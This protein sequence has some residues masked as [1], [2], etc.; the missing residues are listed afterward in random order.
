MPTISPLAEIALRLVVDRELIG[1]EALPELA[2]EQTG[3]ARHEVHLGGEEAAAVAPV[4]LRP[5]HR[6]LGVL[7]QAIGRLAVGREQRDPD[8]GAGVELLA[9]EH[10]RL[11]EAV[12]QT[13]GQRAR[14]LGVA[15]VG[16]QDHELVAA[17]PAD[18][19]GLAQAGMQALGRRLEQQIAAG[20]A[21]GVVDALEAVE[22]EQ[23]HRGDAVGAPR[24]RERMVE[25]VAEQRPIGQPGQRVVPRLVAH[26]RL[27][28]LQLGDVERDR[29]HVGDPAGIVEQ[30][31]LG[32]QQDAL[33][34]GA[35]TGD[36]LLEAR[37]GLAGLEH[38][39]V[40]H[41]V[42]GRMLL[43][44][45]LLQG[46]PDR[47]CRVDPVELLV[48]AVDQ[49]Q[50]AAAVDRA[51]RRGHG[52]DQA[53]QAQLAGAER[54]L[55]LLAA[56]D[57]LAPQLIG[58]L[59]EQL[60]L[61]AQ[62]QEIARPGAE[63]DVVDR[64]QEEVGGAR[65]QRLVAVGAVLV[66]RH[67]HDRNVA[68]AWQ[69]AEGA[70]EVGAVHARHLVVGDHQIG[71]RDQDRIERRL[72]AR[73]CFDPDSLLDRGGQPGKYVPIGHPV[74]DDDDVGHHKQQLG[75]SVRPINPEDNQPAGHA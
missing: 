62:G 6:E 66:D 32:G 29:H 22:V 34:I 65:L 54:R 31:R 53:P 30:R 43:A 15:D 74:I 17:E 11:A 10:E 57:Q 73:E 23:Q 16:L 58:A 19:V 41:Q 26:L 4:G 3:A 69:G 25:V 64:A 24:P 20:Q 72:R 67:H 45:D 27:G 52:V 56:G 38:L 9:V 61:L 39:G 13:A 21:E 28:P 42:L 7:E 47:P 55:V 35:R 60:L 59:L 5:V 12:D 33:L 75:K 46:A 68:R 44:A 70:D 71:Q 2:L 37:Q 63:L 8:A 49:G 36:L 18:R 1:R 40:E 14:L 48:R 50:A 51:D